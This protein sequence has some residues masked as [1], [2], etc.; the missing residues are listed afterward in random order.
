MYGV[1][2]D[3]IFK[4]SLRDS[5]QALVTFV[6][7]IT[8][9]DEHDDVD[10]TLNALAGATGLPLGVLKEGI[11]I[12]EKPDPNSRSKREE[13]RRITRLD[14]HRPWGWHIVNRDFYKRMRDREE[15]RAYQRDWLRDK[16]KR[17]NDVD[18]A[19]TA[20][21]SASTNVDLDRRQETGG[22]RQEEGGTVGGM[23]PSLSLG[24]SVVGERK[25]SRRAADAPASG[26]IALPTNR[27]GQEHHVTQKSLDEL[28]ALYPAL[29]VMQELRGMR[30]WLLANPTNRKTASGMPR[31]VVN[32][33]NKGQNS[34][35]RTQRGGGVSGVALAELAKRMKEAGCE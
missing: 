33:L 24:T 1:I 23:Q 4:S 19:S 22:R 10:M 6:A 34:A 17:G 14:E 15:R 12:L 35:A 2:H 3:S 11:E 27:T 30:A 7:M 16:R 21:D 32:W 29:D 18:R 25:R 9:A 28:V 13:G 20:D 31:F 8:L 5:W 26:V